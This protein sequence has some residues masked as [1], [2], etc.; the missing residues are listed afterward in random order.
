MDVRVE[1]RSAAAPADWDRQSTVAT[2]WWGRAVVVVAILAA[3]A[4]LVVNGDGLSL[5]ELASSPHLLDIDVLSSDPVRSIWFLHAQVPVH[6]AV[7]GLVGWLP[8]PLVGTLFLLHGAAVLATGLLLHAVLVRWGTPPLVA[9]GLAALAMVN[10]ALLDTIRSCGAQVPVALLVVAALYLVQRYLDR[11]RG[12]TLLLL[13]FVLTAGTLTWHMLR[14]LWVVAILAIAVLARSARRSWYRS[15]GWLVA[16]LVIPV[17]LIGGWALKNEAVF[18]EPTLASSVGFDLHQGVTG[19]MSAVGVAGAVEEGTVAPLAQQQPW[20]T[21]GYYGPDRGGT[22]ICFPAHRHRATVDMG[23]AVPD[24]RIAPNYNNECYLPL[25]RQARHDALT[26]ALRYPGRYLTTRDAGLV[27]AYDTADGCAGEPCTWM[28]RLYQPLL[29]KVD[30]QVTMYDWN[31]RLFGTEADHLDVT[32]SMVLVVASA[33]VGWR[34]LVAV[35][36][37]RRIGWRSAARAEWPSGE[38]LWVV[39]AATVVLVIAGT[40]LVEVGDNGRMRTALDPVLLTFPVAAFIRVMWRSGQRSDAGSPPT[41]PSTTETGSPAP[42]SEPSAASGPSA[43]T[44]P[45]ASV[46]PPAAPGPSAVSGP[47]AAGI[48]AGA[49]GGVADVAD[50]R[51]SDDPQSKDV[52][53]NSRSEP[54]ADD[55]RSEDAADDRQSK[56]AADHDVSQDPAGGGLADH[57]P[58]D[59]PPGPDPVPGRPAGGT[60]TTSAPSAIG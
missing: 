30:G 18:G 9:G 24:D 15:L 1:A 20:G 45:S 35:W 43:A 37:L 33:A 21:L 17:V 50:A 39:A 46:G 54:I 5:G 55:G 13:S 38:L 32:L 10:P 51:G 34:G 27:L 31:L 23:K 40:A 41:V 36:R 3:L 12:T 47:E 42:S 26:L 11:P 4:T 53:A 44:R 16:A 57:V 48:P 14:P 6:N 7:V 25:Y 60:G 28:D 52:A 58:S 59:P 2:I 56:D 22:G 8:V 49:D 19:P 29:G